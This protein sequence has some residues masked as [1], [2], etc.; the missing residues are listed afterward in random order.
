MRLLG[1]VDQESDAYLFSAFLT[2]EN[3]RNHY[4]SFTDPK[5][6]VPRYRIWIEEEENFDQA[7]VFFEEFQ[8]DP[9]D[10]KFH[11]LDPFSFSAPP[12]K[13]KSIGKVKLKILPV[14][15]PSAFT[16]TNFF[17]L[18]CVLLFAWQWR[19][20]VEIE[21]KKGPVAIDIGV[22]PLLETLLFDY[23]LQ[24][25]AIQKFIESYPLKDVPDFKSLP[26]PALEQLKKIE[27][28]I[29]AWKGIYDLLMHFRERSA[30]YYKNLRLFEKIR[31]GEVWRFF[32]P[33]LLHGGLVHILFN[34]LLLWYLGKQI[35]RRIAAG[36]LILLVLITGIL[37]NI[38]EYF[39]SG[40]FFLGFSGALVGMAGFIWVRQRRAPWEGYP[41]PA[42][43]ALF[44]LVF[45]LAMLF[46][47]LI[48]FFL[49]ITALSSLTPNIG[50]TAHIT[51]GLSGMLL[52]KFS[53][54][55]RKT[56]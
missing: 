4:E 17:I 36:R 26:I 50:N 33:C 55:S 42:M 53:F 5:V 10:P 39:V 16:V 49:Q 37:G 30:S 28:T 23:T 1:A 27:T 38:G 20:A 21:E 35:E 45:V 13:E 15:V 40:P 19:E 43:T 44:F 7:A 8:K 29:P 47:S 32:T 52:A 46:L 22:T 2:K 41:L 3:I 48:S 14:A 56:P 24:E 18:I 12:L 51:G 31:E 34:M 25:Q 54:F 11:S 9:Q 6:E